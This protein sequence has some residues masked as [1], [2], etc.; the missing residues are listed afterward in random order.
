MKCLVCDVFVGP[1]GKCR[2]GKFPG[3]PAEALLHQKPVEFTQRYVVCSCYTGREHALLTVRAR[4]A[5][6][7]FLLSLQPLRKFYNFNFPSDEERVQ[8]S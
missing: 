3:G 5:V 7:S 1:P 4:V 8:E 6:F 2:R